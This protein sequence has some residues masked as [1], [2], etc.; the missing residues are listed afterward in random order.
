MAAAKKDS[1]PQPGDEGFVHQDGTPQAERQAAENKW[2]AE[3]RAKHGSGVHGAPAGAVALE[4][5]QDDK[6]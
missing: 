1:A 2:A 4:E 3:D 6:S 5:P